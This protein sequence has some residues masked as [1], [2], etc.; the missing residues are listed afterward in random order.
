MTILLPSA[1]AVWPAQNRFEV[2]GTDMTAPVAASHNMAPEPPVISSN[3]NTWL[4]RC[5]SKC[6]GGSGNDNGATHWPTEEGAPDP[7]C[8]PAVR[9]QTSTRRR[10]MTRMSERARGRVM[11]GDLHSGRVDEGRIQRD[12]VRYPFGCWPIIAWSVGLSQRKIC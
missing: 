5:S 3:I 12:V 1:S 4:V 6:T 10:V 9:A 7:V 8:V 2:V 11:R